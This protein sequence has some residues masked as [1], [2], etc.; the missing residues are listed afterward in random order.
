MERYTG[1]ASLWSHV[2]RLCLC[3]NKG[4]APAGAGR[5]RCSGGF[6]GGC[7]QLTVAFF[8]DNGLVAARCPERLQSSFTIFII[9]FECIGLWTNAAKTKVMRC[10]PRKIRVARTEE[11]Y[12]AQ[13]TG[14][15]VIFL[16]TPFVRLYLP[17]KRPTAIFIWY[18]SYALITRFC[19][20]L[21]PERTT[22][23]N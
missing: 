22:K 16:D 10:L 4:V 2:Q 12:A 15:C 7:T 23:N 8:V 11:E 17:E 13:Q 6:K 14:R 1:G 19:L 21:I 18:D 5:R 9:L 20:I 3:G